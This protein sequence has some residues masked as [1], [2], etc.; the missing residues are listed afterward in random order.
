L[1]SRRCPADDQVVAASGT[2][3]TLSGSGTGTDFTDS[4]EH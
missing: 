2:N 1:P 3:D 4:I